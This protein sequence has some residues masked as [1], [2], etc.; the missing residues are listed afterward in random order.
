MKRQ[1]TWMHGAREPHGQ[2]HQN[3]TLLW[4]WSQSPSPM[5]PIKMNPHTPVAYLHLVFL[6]KSLT[7]HIFI[8]TVHYHALSNSI[9]IHLSVFFT[10]FF[11]CDF[12]LKLS[13]WCS[14]LVF[15]KVDMTSTQFLYR[16]HCLGKI[17]KLRNHRYSDDI[18]HV[19]FICRS[20][21]SKKE[22]KV[23][24]FALKKSEKKGR[25]YMKLK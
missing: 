24:F 20:C 11:L 3:T 13:R 5:P 16:L 18:T 10:I 17:T 1:R 4:G 7:V 19:N 15:S 12:L 22:T 25:K 23:I 8:Y 2:A 14:S 21:I 6:C 9:I